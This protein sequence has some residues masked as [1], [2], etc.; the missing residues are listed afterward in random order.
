[1]YI[2]LTAPSRVSGVSLTKTVK[3]GTSALRVTWTTPQS[4]VAIS[5]YQVQYRRSGMTSWSSATPLSGSPPATSTILTG[6]DA[7]TKYNIRVRAVSELGAGEW[8][9]EQTERTFGS[10]F[11]CML[12]L[13]FI[14]SC[15]CTFGTSRW[16]MSTASEVCLYWLTVWF[17]HIILY[18]HSYACDYMWCVCHCINKSYN[19]VAVLAPIYTS[20]KENV[21]ICSKTPAHT[22]REVAPSFPNLVSSPQSPRAYYC[23]IAENCPQLC[24]NKLA[25]TG[26]WTR[27]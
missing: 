17:H 13:L 4:D 10:K 15:I 9:V 22:M 24:N 1:M 23:A 12:C 20:S 18:Y 26:G 21:F 27:D 11:V 6:L 14:I 2:S 7:G 16:D 19:N 8:S 5:K 25:E 3:N